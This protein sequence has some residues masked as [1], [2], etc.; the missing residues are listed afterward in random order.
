MKSQVDNDF[1]AD[2]LKQSSRAYNLE[3]VMRSRTLYDPYRRKLRLDWLELPG[4]NAPTLRY[5]RELDLLDASARFL[6]VERD[7]ATYLELCEQYG[8]SSSDHAF[9]HGKLELLVKGTLLER[10]GVCNW[11]TEQLS[12]GE[13][14]RANLAVM[15]A[16]AKAQAKRLGGFALIINVGIDRGFSITDFR[17]SLATCD[18]VV[19]DA[20]LARPGATYGSRPGRPSSRVNYCIHFGPVAPRLEIHR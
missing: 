14:F 1:S 12:G 7:E 3:E 2:W 5:L 17:E 13:A 19:S 18:H 20:E 16:F 8:E 15:W 6:G 9:V 10:S 11:D 4:R